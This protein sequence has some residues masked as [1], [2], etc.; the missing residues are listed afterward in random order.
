MTATTITIL[1]RLTRDVELRSTP[2]GT[3]IAKV[4]LAVDDSY[5]DASGTTVE[6]TV[7]IDAAIFGKRGEAF[8]RFH[9]KGSACFLF[10]SLA[11]DTWED[12]NTGQK[13]TKHYVKVRDWEFVPKVKDDDAQGSH[14]GQQREYNYSGNA[15][16]PQD[17][18]Q[19]DTY[20]DTP[21]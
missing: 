16:A 17:G 6:K 3:S 18:G 14:R 9:R 15:P 2:S 21:F 5:T 7:F 1:A 4:G 11:M 12:K 19:A 8:E 13:R 20:E 10:G